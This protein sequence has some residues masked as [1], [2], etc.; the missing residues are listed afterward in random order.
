MHGGEGPERSGM[1]QLLSGRLINQSA[2]R[3]HML[4]HC[5]SPDKN[6]MLACRPAVET[7]LATY[8]DLSSANRARGLDASGAARDIMVSGLRGAGW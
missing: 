6:T 4:S 5:W 8:L 7:W 3:L 2:G 1:N